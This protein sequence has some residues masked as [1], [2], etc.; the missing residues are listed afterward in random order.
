MCAVADSGLDSLAAGGRAA[1][2]GR[3]AGF[4][5]HAVIIS[6]PP[7]RASFF[8]VTPSARE[9]GHGWRGHRLERTNEAAQ[10]EAATAQ[11]YPQPASTDHP[12]GQECRVSRDAALI[13]VAIAPVRA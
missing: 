12:T 4:V 13:G 7:T 1:T 6:N 8:T 10:L 2:C 9:D 5:A 11:L 3:G